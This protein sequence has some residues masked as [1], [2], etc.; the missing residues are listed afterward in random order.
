MISLFSPLFFFLT[1][2]FNRLHS[3]DSDLIY[4]ISST[5]TIAFDAHTFLRNNC[6]DVYMYIMLRT[7]QTFH[8]IYF[9]IIHCILIGIPRA[10]VQINTLIRNITKILQKYYKTIQIS[11]DILQ[12]NCRV[13]VMRYFLYVLPNPVDKVG[14]Y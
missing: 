14:K 9:I 5:S 2:Y 10:F 3:D 12:S 11:T 13:E 8:C 4:Q 6:T 7:I 1:A